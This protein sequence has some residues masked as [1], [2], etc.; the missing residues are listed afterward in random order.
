MSNQ[1]TPRL[2]TLVNHPPRVKL[3]DWNLPS[4][5]P[6]FQAA[7][8]KVDSLNNW[9]ERAN[10]A[11]DDGKDLFLYSRVSNPTLRELELLLA[12]MQNHE[13]SIVFASGMA[14][15]STALISLLGPGD[16]AI[17]FKEGYAPSRGVVRGILGRYGIRYRFL[18]ITKL[19]ELE[20]ALAEKLP[21]SGRRVILFESPTNPVLRVADLDRLCKAAREH[22]AITI[23]DNTFAGLHQHGAAAVDLILHSLT[24]YAAGHGDVTAGALIGPRKFIHPIRETATLLGATLDP[25]AAFLIQRGLKTYPLRYSAQSRGALEVARFLARHPAVERVFY[26]GLETDPGHSLA[27]KQM[28]E[29][30]GMLS[31]RLRSLKADEFVS[32]LR[33]FAFTVSLGSTESLATPVIQLYGNDLSP[34]ELAAC[35]VTEQTVR[36]SIGLEDPADLIADISQ[37]LDRG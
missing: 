23:L 28:K 21:A 8:F 27:K 7:K 17:L 37:A 6:I 36:L 11:R 30:G 14:A 19:E 22:G 31:V 35:D 33:L 4:A 2:S 12:G 13:D 15:V 1:K 34:A 16:E 25:H 10:E 26:P 18:S 9:L 20:S 5:S 32:R 29:M 3:E 24:K